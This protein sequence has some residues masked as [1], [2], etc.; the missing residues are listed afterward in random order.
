MDHFNLFFIS[1]IDESANNV[2]EESL[3]TA[4]KK[5]NELQN[6]EVD[7]HKANLELKGLQ[8]AEHLHRHLTEADICLC[9]IT[10]TNPNVMYEIGYARAIGKKTIIIRQTGQKIPVDITDKYVQEYTASDLPS[11]GEFLETAIVKAIEAVLTRRSSARPQYP[12]VCF[13]DR[14]SSDLGEAIRNAA[15]RIDILETNVSTI[16]GGQYLPDI[17]H[18]LNSHERL[19]IRVLALDPDSSFV[20]NRASQLGVP[21]GQYRVELHRAIQRLQQELNP[22]SARFTL[23]IYN[24]FPTQ[25]T[26]LVDDAVFSCSISRGNRSRNLC[27]F[28]VYLYDSGAE[29][30]FGFHFEAVWAFGEVYVPFG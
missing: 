3:N 29:R 5:V 13:Q 8:F 22:Y 17:V 23:R 2:W 27:T 21:V 24:D 4:I 12:V 26:F 28:K 18:A 20:N 9:D 25:I 14:K 7:S 1:P 6:Y 30:T 16:V 10:G 15:E 11:L 19:T